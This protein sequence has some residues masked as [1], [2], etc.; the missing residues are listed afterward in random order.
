[1]K[2]YFAAS[3]RGGRDNQE[4]CQKIIPYLKK[5]GEVLTEHLADPKLSYLGEPLP[6]K[7]VYNRDMDFLREADVLI[8][9]ISVPSLGVGYEIAKAE[10][11]GKKIL[12]FCKKFE[13]G[14]KL[15]TIIEGNSNL[16]IKEY[17]DLEE[18]FQKIDEFFKI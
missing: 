5:F 6:A 8:A 18:V 11:L 17:S 4:A 15:S 1:M 16:I 2:I 14:S 10:E 7:D 9:E 3:I 12:Y 13:D